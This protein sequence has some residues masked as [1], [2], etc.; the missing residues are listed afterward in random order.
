M[1]KTIKVIPVFHT[2]GFEERIDRNGYSERTCECCGRK[3]NPA[4]TKWVQMLET[5]E[6]TD[7]EKEVKE[8]VNHWGRSQGCFGVGPDCY[9]LIR[10]R[11]DASTTTRVA[12]V[13]D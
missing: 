8:L 2:E 11:L 10:A 9:K 5:G 7:E 6:W 1:E 3:L 4:R 12:I 13:N